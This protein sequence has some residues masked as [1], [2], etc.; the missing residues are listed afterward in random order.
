MNNARAVHVPKLATVVSQQEVTA[1]WDRP[2]AANTVES[3]LQGGKTVATAGRLAVTGDHRARTQWRD[4][5]NE[6]GAAI[7]NDHI[8]VRF[9]KQISQLDEVAGEV[10][11]AAA[12]RP[13]L[14]FGAGAEAGERLIVFYPQAAPAADRRAVRGGH[15]QRRHDAVAI[16][17]ANPPV[18]GVEDVNGAIAAH[19][20]AVGK[21][22]IQ[23]GCRSRTIA[24]EPAG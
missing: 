21:I 16:H 5:V 14:E 15:E 7:T 6:V 10:L 8:A 18:V 12:R 1:G 4:T 2:R 22:Q 24:V 11:H 3:G 9:N 13:L 23:I 19:P 20:L 17:T